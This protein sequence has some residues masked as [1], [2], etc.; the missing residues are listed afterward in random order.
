[1][2]AELAIANAAFGVIKEAIGN[3][4]DLY[5]MGG[6]VA[7]FFDQKTALQKKSNA[8]GYKSDMQAFMELEKIKEMEE[9]LKDQMIWAGRPGMWD[10]WLA[11]QKQAKE[12]REKRERE[13][14]Q[15]HDEMMQLIMYV[16]YGICG[17]VVFVPTLFLILTILK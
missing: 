8:K 17:L 10:D 2:L 15:R 14:R 1:M 7:Q 12:E 13:E 16:V 6:V 4:K 5:E 9:H 11:F 3:G